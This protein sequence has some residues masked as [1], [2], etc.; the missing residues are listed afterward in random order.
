MTCCGDGYIVK[1]DG[2]V[3]LMWLLGCI[4]ESSHSQENYKVLDSSKDLW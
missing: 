3:L 2:D 4:L 1:S